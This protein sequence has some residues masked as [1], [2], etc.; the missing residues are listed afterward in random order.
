[1]SRGTGW[2]G[3]GPLVVG[4]T[5]LVLMA[6]GASGL[7]D[8]EEINKS[9]HEAAAKVELILRSAPNL[10]VARE[11]LQMLA[12]EGE[13][14]DLRLLAP[15]NGME[16]ESASAWIDKERD[17]VYEAR[18]DHRDSRAVLAGRIAFYGGLI[19]VF[20]A[21]VLLYRR[22]PDSVHKEW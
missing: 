6:C 1:M 2:W 11:E 22:T 9:A 15:Q 21:G 13:P 5:G 10:A 17:A 20:A 18:S 12:D 16:S 8:S 19:L 14:V 3:T 7:P 4:A